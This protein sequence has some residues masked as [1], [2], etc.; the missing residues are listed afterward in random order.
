MRFVTKTWWV[1]CQIFEHVNQLIPWGFIS[2]GVYF[3]GG[4][5]PWGLFSVGVYFLSKVEW[6]FFFCGG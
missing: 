3:R 1:D 6:G 4:L 5:F 2:V